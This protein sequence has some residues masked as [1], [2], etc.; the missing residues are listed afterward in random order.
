[1][2]QRSFQQGLGAVNLLTAEGSS[3]TVPFPQ[4]SNHVFRSQE[5]SKYLSYEAH[6]LFRNIQNL[7]YISETQEKTQKKY[8]V[9]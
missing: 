4:S 3:E 7:M 1:M 2:L 8:L 9:F 6:L 5:F